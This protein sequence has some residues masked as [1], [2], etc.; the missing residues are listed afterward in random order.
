MENA[1]V[2][3]VF[4]SAILLFCIAFSRLITK[5]GIP[6]LVFFIFAGMI[7]GSEGAG[8]IY[9]DNASA[10][11]SIGN[12]ALCYIIFA[13]GMA[14][15]WKSAREVLL[16]GALLSTAGVM[17]TAI[18]VGVAAHFLLGLT[19]MQGL[20]LGSVVSCTDAASVFSILRSNNMNLKAP[21]APLLELESSSNDPAAYM[22]TI[23]I[24]SLMKSDGGGFFG[25]ALMF[26]MQL[27]VGAG[28]GFAFGFAGAL[29]INRIRL[30][31]DG[32]YPVVA[33]TIASFVFA[34]VQ[35]MRGNGLLGVYIA[36]M[37]MGNVKLVHKTSLVRFFDGF[38]WLM[39]ILVFV[40]LG[41]LVFP[42]QL[43]AVW[44]PALVMS[45][46]LMFLIRP[47]AVFITLSGFK[48]PLKAK[49]FVSWVGLRGASSIVFATYALTEGIQNADTSFNMVFFIS[50]TSVIIQGSMLTPVAS[51]LGQLDKEDKTLVS[52]SFTDYEEDIQG[53]LYELRAV[54]GSKAVGMAVSDMKFPESVRI[55]L[56]KRGESTIAP[57]GKTLIK[58]G[59]TL[60]VTTGKTEALLAL[61]ERLALV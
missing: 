1:N 16:P 17:I 7:M 36:A 13:G 46:A 33:A 23:T 55:M 42:S 51:M 56:I 18:L 44:L 21:L 60:M 14:T 9:F 48:Y 34:A 59:D 2:L 6:V 58:E 40:T 45:A 8:G 29:L 12:F 31:S 53:T 30:N 11:S 28:L 35:L 50:L 10:A 20:L 5:A 39:Q 19:L 54:R 41:L 15:S 38:S 27:A 3:I 24:I 43:R 61:K 25:Y 47:A 4:V 32:L 57:T 22:L 26:V 37:V 52:R 49:L